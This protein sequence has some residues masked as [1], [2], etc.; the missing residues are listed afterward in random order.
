MS[1]RQLILFSIL[2]IVCITFLALGEQSKLYLSTRLSAV[3]L[4]PVKT[5]TD[6]LHFLTISNAR[7]TELE[8][9]VNQLRLENSEL[10]KRILLDTI[11][12]KTTKY[13]LLKAQIIG[14]DPSNINGYLYI[15]K[16]KEDDVK[17]NQPVISIN[18]LVGKIKLIT[19][20]YSVV[21]T[22]ENQGFAVSAVDI[23]TKIHGVVK[24]KQNLIFDFIRIDDEIAVGDSICTSGMSEIFPQGILIGIVKKIEEQNTLFFKPVYI[25][26]SV[27]I[28]KL[29]YVYVISNAETGLPPR[30]IPTGD[31]GD[32]V[33]PP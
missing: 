10:K 5:V 2:L 33:N 6:F 15:N 26:P 12:F 3:L 11:E 24:K 31:I 8:T 13:E 19:E 9:L 29:T 28:N 1:R 23:N 4:F 22:I 17:I 18:G 30:L 25:K 21:E 20:K 32:M 7:I 27:Q 16:G 14:R